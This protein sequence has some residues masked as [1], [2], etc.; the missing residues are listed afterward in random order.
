[1]N[2]LRLDASMRRQGSVTRALA[3]KVVGRLGEAGAVQVVHRDLADGL[4]A[5]DEAWIG[6]NFTAPEERSAAQRAALGLSDRLVAELKAADVLVI[7]L[8]VYNFG[9]PA[10]LKAWIDQIAR[11]R[12]TFRY[13]E[14]GPKGLLEG[15]RAI[16][17]MASGGVEA[18]SPADFATPY[19]RH[20]LAFVG[21]TEVEII[22]AGGQS[23]RADAVE[24]AEAEI[25]ALAA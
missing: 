4:P 13:T 24:T 5:I 8:P 21:I 11:A 2:I 6:A 14:N 10:A 12:V 1:M 7:G 18:G 3:G 20:A 23:L 15:K 16:V 9:M 22:S 19:L 25:A 17:V